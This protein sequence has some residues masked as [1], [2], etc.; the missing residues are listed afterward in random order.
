[1]AKVSTIPVSIEK[2]AAYLDGNLSIEDTQDMAKLIMNDSS[3]LD[4]LNVNTNVDNQIHQMTEDGIE[5]PNDIITSDLEF[6]QIDDVAGMLSYDDS[7]TI[8]ANEENSL[9]INDGC[10]D[11]NNEDSLFY[12]DSVNFNENNNFEVFPS[13]DNDSISESGSNLDFLNNN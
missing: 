12:Q 7:A 5:L 1:M 11:L 8:I 3:L 6:P 9:G 13:N 4:I 2:F 10:D